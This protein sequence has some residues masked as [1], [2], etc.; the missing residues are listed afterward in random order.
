[1]QAA[2][3]AVLCGFLQAYAEKVAAFQHVEL[4][5]KRAS[6]EC[7][8][9]ELLQYG[10]QAVRARQMPPPPPP[11]GGFAA[12]QAA[13]SLGVP[14][15]SGQALPPQ[16]DV[17]S[18]GVQQGQQQQPITAAFPYV[19]AEMAAP[20]ENSGAP[21]LAMLAQDCPPICLQQP[22]AACPTHCLRNSGLVMPP[23]QADY[24][25]AGAAECTPK[26]TWKCDQPECDEV[27]TPQC[28]QPEC[29]VRCVP[30]TSNCEM[31]CTQPQCMTVC[32]ER[33]C[34][35]EGC[36]LCQTQCSEPVCKL[37]CPEVQN[38]HTVCEQPECMWDCKAPAQCPA[39][40]C[41]MACERPPNC[42]SQSYQQLPPLASGEMAVHSFMA[43]PVTPAPPP[44]GPR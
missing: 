19:P 29:E 36:P 6:T 16:L 8:T 42:L 12:Q 5:E 23:A 20:G 13:V 18:L 1:M 10:A 15:S 27:C 26:C 32:P 44:R 30:D 35:Y 37:R 11:P 24:L 39:P 9:L 28:K 25:S 34:P 38:C 7:E 21:A 3:I 22:H 2:F 40:K 4:E 41:Q 43:P 31:D 17:Q 33:A 14:P